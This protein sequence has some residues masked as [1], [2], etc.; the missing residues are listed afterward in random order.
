MRLIG[1]A[2]CVCL[3]I[4]V[5][6]VAAVSQAGDVVQLK[7]F[8]GWWIG[9]GR[10]GYKSGQIEKVKCRATYRRAKA[11]DSMK[12]SFRCATASGAVDISSQI[13]LVG[14]KLVGSWKERKYEVEGQLEGKAVPGGFRVKVS[15]PDVNA[16]MTV[17]LRGNRQAFE[18]QFF[19]G[20]LLGLSVVMQRG[21]S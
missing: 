6:P 5:A 21:S 14:E 19:S 1:F 17:I 8:H 16:N 20:S 2:L 7:Q 4:A 10:L 9:R 11:A 12:Q 15:G 3:S 13:R 18:L